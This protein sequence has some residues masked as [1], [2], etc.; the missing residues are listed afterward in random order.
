MD[1]CAVAFCLVLASCAGTRSQPAP[2]IDRTELPAES[3]QESAS[4]SK[5]GVDSTS[6]SKKSL[7][8]NQYE[9]VKGD[10]LYSIGKKLGIS[11]QKI[12]EANNIENNAIHVGQVLNIPGTNNSSTGRASK[13]ENAESGV[14][15]QPLKTVDT[16]K[17][18][19]KPTMVDGVPHYDY[20]KATR[21][22][23]SANAKPIVTSATKSS[24]AETKP[25]ANKTEPTKPT[26][27]SASAETSNSGSV[28]IDTL[29]DQNIEWRWPAKGKLIAE[30]DKRTNKGID[31]AGNVGQPIL[32]ASAGKVIYSG[33]DIRG[34]GKL[35]II[36]HN[37]N[38]LSVY[39]HQGNIFVKEGQFVNLHDKISEMGRDNAST[40]KLHFEIRK[41]G[42][43]VDPKDYLPS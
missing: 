18:E 26:E 43:T 10:T 24:P 30:Y 41:K 34:Y 42:K 15:T 2:V 17:A 13:S 8:G 22:I 38:Y 40:T 16:P 3:R 14:T 7:S 23:A 5:S 36:K 25:T 12:A 32:A 35:V 20:P 9:V 21:D 28:D 33:T 29:Q 1:S 27:N 6:A 11:Y 31:I 39:A 37:R 19:Q 4:S